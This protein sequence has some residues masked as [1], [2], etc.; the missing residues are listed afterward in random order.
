MSPPLFAIKSHVLKMHQYENF[1]GRN[2]SLLRSLLHPQYR[3]QCLCIDLCHVFYLPRH[4]ESLL[5][6]GKVSPYKPCLPRVEARKQISQPPLQLRQRHVT[7]TLPASCTQGSSVQ[8]WATQR[9]ALCPKSNFSSQGDNWSIRLS[10]PES[11]PW[12][13]PPL[14]RST[15]S[16]YRNY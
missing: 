4:F 8:K 11:F 5:C 13:S 14:S 12:T 3:A 16:L 9:R 10:P 6:L 2:N 1:T 7:Q 15:L